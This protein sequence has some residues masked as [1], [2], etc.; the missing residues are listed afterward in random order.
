MSEIF[1]AADLLAKVFDANR[2]HEFLRVAALSAGVYVLAAGAEDRQRP[3][4]QDEIYYVIRGQ[5]KMRLGSNERAVHEGD[6]IFVE[7]KLDHKFFDV[8]Q[9]LELLVVFAPAETE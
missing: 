4:N 7:A 1:A 3:H 2:Y 8:E 6:V 9:Q 5:A